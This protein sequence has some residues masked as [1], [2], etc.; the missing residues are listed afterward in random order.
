MMS[1]LI[2]WEW[3]NFF[4][5]QW[6]RMEHQRGHTGLRV[7]KE[8][9]SDPSIT[10]GNFSGKV[11]VSVGCL[12]ECWKARLAGE[13][14]VGAAKETGSQGAGC[15]HPSRCSQTTWQTRNLYFKCDE[16]FSEC[17]SKRCYRVFSVCKG[18]S[19][20]YG[21]TKTFSCAPKHYQNVSA[22][23]WLLC[24][25]DGIGWS[26]CWRHKCTHFHFVSSSFFPLSPRVELSSILY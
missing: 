12:G 13:G 18:L 24:P 4:R 25:E 3:R 16:I 6:P 1:R 15:T 22:P 8:W 11:A 26:L 19:Y 9:V 17:L 2:K 23:N 5:Y 10:L 20:C 21:G 14:D 7:E